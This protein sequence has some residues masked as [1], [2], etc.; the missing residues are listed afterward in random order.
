MSEP[1]EQSLGLRVEREQETVRSPASFEG[2]GS[3]ALT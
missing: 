2:P 3:T 1:A